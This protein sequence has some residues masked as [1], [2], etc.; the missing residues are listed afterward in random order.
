MEKEMMT[1]ESEMEKM[2][3]SMMAEMMEPMMKGM[4]AGM[5]GEPKKEKELKSGFEKAWAEK[6]KMEM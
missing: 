1:K 4:M 3:K 2:M 6:E 5:M